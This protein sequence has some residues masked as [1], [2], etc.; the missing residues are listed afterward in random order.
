MGDR[1]L[2]R[3]TEERLPHGPYWTIN[4]DRSANGTP[5]L[6][7]TIHHRT[8]EDFPVEELTVHVEDGNEFL[9]PVIA[10]LAANP[11]TLESEKKE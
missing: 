2:S 4:I 11:T 10:W 5:G 6:M 3:A 1:T 7:I 8:A 9:K